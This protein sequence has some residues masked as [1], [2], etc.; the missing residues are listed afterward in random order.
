VIASR[1]AHAVISPRQNAKLWKD[2]KAHSLERD[3]LLRTVKH[4]G[5]MI[6]ENWA[7]Y[8]RRSL[9]ETKMSCFKLSRDKL[10]ARK[11]QS[12]VKEIHVRVAVLNKFIELVLSHT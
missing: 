10:N 11:V 1:K 6:W 8:Y 7:G 12:Q 4:L 5:R 3:E 9:V 2:T